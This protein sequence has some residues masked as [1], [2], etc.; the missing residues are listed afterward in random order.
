MT[1]AKPTKTTVLLRRRL[2][3]RAARKD[4]AKMGRCWSGGV[5][6]A[7]EMS[8]DAAAPVK[9][10]DELPNHDNCKQDERQYEQAC[11]T[12]CDHKHKMIATQCYPR[13]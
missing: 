9:K 4:M 12:T 13:C 5:P 10:Q 1:T 3:C 6:V 7:A 11:E 2:L 8:A